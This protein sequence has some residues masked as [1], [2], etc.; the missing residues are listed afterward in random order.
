MNNAD[1]TAA[2]IQVAENQVACWIDFSCQAS[3]PTP[4]VVLEA[5]GNKVDSISFIDR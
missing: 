5:E 1:A 4:F 2:G 3:C